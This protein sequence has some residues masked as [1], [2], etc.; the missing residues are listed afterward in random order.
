MP[1]INNETV[2]MN[3]IVYDVVNGRGKVVGLSTSTIE[4]RFDNG[5]RIT[6]S[7]EGYLNG[8]RRLFWHNP[9]VLDPPK[10][11]NDWEYTKKVIVTT[12]LL[13]TDRAAV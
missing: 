2:K 11:F 4:V 3:D 10:S 1:V 5:R 6:F 7:P 9:L 8:I 12:Y 13:L